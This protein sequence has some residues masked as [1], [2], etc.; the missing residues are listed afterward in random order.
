MNQYKN[1]IHKHIISCTHLYMRATYMCVN[2]HTHPWSTTNAFEH[3]ERGQ[4]MCR[5]IWLVKDP[6]SPTHIFHTF[7]A[8]SI[9]TVWW[10]YAYDICLVTKTKCIT[11]YVFPIFTASNH[12]CFASMQKLQ[13]ATGVISQ[14]MVVLHATISLHTIVCLQKTFGQEILPRHP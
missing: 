9:E 14:V 7:L 10:P 12:Y 1:L 13:L 3:N 4:I 11:I 2:K 8:D 5:L 6:H